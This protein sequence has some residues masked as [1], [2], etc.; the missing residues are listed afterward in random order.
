MHG[1]QAVSEI[2]EIDVTGSAEH[3]MIRVPA[4]VAFAWTA[5]GCVAITGLQSLN[6]QGKREILG[7][8]RI[9][10][11]AGSEGQPDLYP[12]PMESSLADHGR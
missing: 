11:P 4:T 2:A 9:S 5:T 12:N 3:R 6:A 1:L 8:K 10:P 7:G